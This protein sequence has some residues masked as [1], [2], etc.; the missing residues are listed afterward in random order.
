M[1][2]SVFQLKP[3]TVHRIWKQEMI[4]GLRY[5]VPFSFTYVKKSFNWA[6]VV[7][8]EIP[9]TFWGVS[10]DFRSGISGKPTL[11]V[12]AIV[13]E[14]WMLSASGA[15]WSGFVLWMHD[16]IH[17]LRLLIEP[18]LGFKL[19]LCSWAHAVMNQFQSCGVDTMDS[20]N[21]LEA[22]REATKSPKWSH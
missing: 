18:T 13:V 16:V 8:A 10:I 12:L 15:G 14:R 9:V 2:G 11:T 4:S 7:E 20:K 21:Q 22:S 1:A 3:L 6:S 5:E 19:L 17:A